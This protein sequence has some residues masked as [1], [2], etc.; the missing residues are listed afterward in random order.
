MTEA[1]QLKAIAAEFQVAGWAVSFDP[2]PGSF[3]FPEDM[4]R[5]DMV[6]Y[7]NGDPMPEYPP[8]GPSI[9]IVEVAN[10][11]RR[12]RK[13]TGRAD[14]PYW[15]E[16]DEEE[17]QYRFER[18]SD[19]LQALQRDDI[20]FQVRFLDV[21]ADQAEARTF[22]DFSPWNTEQLLN[23]MRDARTRLANR[24]RTADDRALEVVA[25]WARALRILGHRFPG[26]RHKELQKA[27]LRT[28]QKDLYDAG[29]IDTPPS[30]Y[31]RTHQSILALFEGGSPEWPLLH[32]LEADLNKILDH[33]ISKY[34]QDEAETISEMAAVPPQDEDAERDLFEPLALRLG[35][36][37]VQPIRRLATDQL[38][39]LRQT[40]LTPAFRQALIDFE[41]TISSER[42]R[43]EDLL[44][45][46][47][48]R[49]KQ[50]HG[51]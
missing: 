33:I 8:P 14:H 36:I 13:E 35:Q 24:Q 40:D 25:T 6:A 17:A 51:V 1:D 37:E 12:N 32:S 34:L 22:T 5:L 7:R 20:D 38:A 18:I 10:R 3:N 41:Q 19:S 46:L 16:L 31:V 27:D 21:S 9:I 30:D 43:F 26:R 45:L 47:R 50:I 11:R 28:I 4:P 2:L 49:S 48:E 29:V 15:A 42:D 39:L 44:S 23:E